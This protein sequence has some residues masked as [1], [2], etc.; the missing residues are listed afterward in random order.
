MDKLFHCTLYKGCN[1]LSILGLKLIH[2]SKRATV[3]IRAI[4]LLSQYLTH[5]GRVTHICVTKLTI[6][7]SDDGLSPGQFQAIIWTNARIVSIRPLAINLNEILIEMFIHVNALEN[8]VLKM[9]TILFLPQWVKADYHLLCK[10]RWIHWH[11]RFQNIRLKIIAIT[12]RFSAD[13][14]NLGEWHQTNLGLISLLRPSFPGM[15]IPMLRDR[16]IFNMGILYW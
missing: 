12:C 7:D 14:Y 16:P 4:T 1:Y 11:S 15:E 9:T 8:C 13:A 2:V 5:W 6:I 10:S 3:D